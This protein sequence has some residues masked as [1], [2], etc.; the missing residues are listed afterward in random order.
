MT[1]KVTIGMTFLPQFPPEVLVDFARQVEAAGFD[2]LWLYEDCFYGGGFASAATL[3]AATER[4]AVGIGLL[5]ALVRNP[6]FAA[7]EIATLAR[8]YPGR[9]LPGFGHGFEPWMEQIGVRAKSPLRALEETV[10]ATGRLLAGEEVTLH[11]EQVHLDRV[12][13]LL[14]PQV[15]PPLYVG[16]VRE[17]TLRLA[18]RV[19]DGTLL[20]VL[21]SP[22]YVRWASAQIAVGAGQRPNTRC[23]SVACSVRPDG[24]AARQEARRWLAEA[25]QHGGPHLQPLGIDEEA[26]QFFSRHGVEEGARRMPDAWVDALSASGTPEQ[27]AEAVQR[28]VEAGADAVVLAPVVYDPACL[29]DIVRGLMPLLKPLQQ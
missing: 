25:I 22:E 13:L 2:S 27:A 4:I 26:R 8:L 10:Q 9:F 5:P 12:K 1:A 20:S 7:M 28:L 18:G 16:G 11:G 23:V 24:A 15:V 6:L 17:K 21:S 19:G 3:L 29:Q 14:P